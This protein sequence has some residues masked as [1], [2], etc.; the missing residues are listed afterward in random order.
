MSARGFAFSVR[1]ADACF[2]GGR[3]RDEIRDASRRAREVAERMGKTIKTYCMMSVVAADSDAEA[4]KIVK[5]YND[6]LDEGAVI[7]M[8]DSWG[9]QRDADTAIFYS[10]SNC[11]EGLRGISFGNF[12]IKQVVEELKAELPQLSRFA[13]LSPVPGF[14]RWLDRQLA[15]PPEGGL[16]RAEEVAVLGG[17][18][19]AEAFKAMTEGAWWEDDAKREALR[20]PLLRLAAAYLTRPN[21]GMG[22]IDPV[23]RFHLGNGAQLERINWLGNVSARGMRESYGIMVNYLYDPG[24]IEANHE[25]FVHSGQVVRSAAVDGLLQLPRLMPA[26]APRSAFTRLLGGEEKPTPKPA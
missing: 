18:D 23:A 17:T 8:M 12:L 4:Q 13:T 14:R 15:S 11:Q 6:G 9:L 26:A 16:F 22:N 2:I 5:R 19:P 3:S 7:G 24:A 20:A 10:I 1:H 25:A 21:S